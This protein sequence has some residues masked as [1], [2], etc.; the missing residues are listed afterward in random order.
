MELT[1]KSIRIDLGR[2]IEQLRKNYK[3]R[4]MTREALAEKLDIDPI[5][6]YRWEKG[7]T[8][9]SLESIFKIAD[10]FHIPISFLFG[11][12]AYPPTVEA[13]AEI[14]KKQER[15][16]AKFEKKSIKNLFDVVSGMSDKELHALV[17]LARMIRDRRSPEEI[18]RDLR[19]LSALRKKVR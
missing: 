15:E 4:K 8:S 17:D 6:I 18:A 9:P 5:S 3:P 2:R 14:I 16:L 12:G 11:E 19:R 1:E 7:Q 10:I 13:L